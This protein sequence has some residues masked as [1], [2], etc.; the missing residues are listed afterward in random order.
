MPRHLLAALALVAVLVFALAAPALAQEEQ[1]TPPG[2]E[3]QPGA[4]QEPPA[5][6]GQPET[7]GTAGGEAPATGG[8]SLPYTG[9][10]ALWIALAGI[11][12]LLAGARLR[13]LTR[14]REAVRRY[15]T[16]KSAL[17]DSLEQ[18][19]AEGAEEERRATRGPPPVEPSTPG[20][21]RMAES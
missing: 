9:L 3:P 8:G 13:V 2:G 15:R 12:L 18:L 6:P 21:R 10:E 20:A 17:Q 11:A 4:P 7:P 5:D 1:P 14:L 16:P 19:R